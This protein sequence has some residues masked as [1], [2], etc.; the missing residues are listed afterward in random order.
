MSVVRIEALLTLN[1]FFFNI[2]FGENGNQ[3]VKNGAK[4]NLIPKI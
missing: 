4:Y 3:N 1:E 2:S